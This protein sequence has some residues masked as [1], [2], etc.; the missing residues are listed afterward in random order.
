MRRSIEVNNIPEAGG[1][2]TGTAMTKKVSLKTEIGGEL[3]HYV[4]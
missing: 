4:T 2:T 1:F 3:L